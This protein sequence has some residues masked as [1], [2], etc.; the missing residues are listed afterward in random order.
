MPSPERGQALRARYNIAPDAVVVAQLCWMVPVKGVDTL[1]AA[2]VES[3]RDVPTAH[4]LLVG[5][6][7]QLEDYR[8]LATELHIEDRVTF[9]GVISD[10]TANGVFEAADL[11]CQPSLWQ[12]AS[13]LAVM[14]AM[15]F[16]LPVVVSRIGGLPELVHDGSNGFLFTPSNAA[17]LSE[18]LVRLAKSAELRHRLGTAGR[19]DIAAHHQLQDTVDRYVKAV[20]EG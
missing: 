5:D 19:A 18:K 4:F 10:P 3:L 12:E 9:T 2:A 7:P 6:G 17:D 11:Y 14:E 13:G 20:L 8:R 15:S 1:L 16:G